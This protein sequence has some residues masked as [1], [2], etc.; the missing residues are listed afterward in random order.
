[1][2]SLD[3][4]ALG[5]H[6]TQDL[7]PMDWDNNI[8]NTND[9]RFQAIAALPLPLYSFALFLHRENVENTRYIW[10]YECAVGLLS[11]MMEGHLDITDRDGGNH[12]P[13]QHYTR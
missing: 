3:G 11:D 8:I 9:F 13:T 7:I 4:E 1:M 12:L 2:I 5:L 6:Y 10:L